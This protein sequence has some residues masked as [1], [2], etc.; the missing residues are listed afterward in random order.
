MH[1][2]LVSIEA[3]LPD[4]KPYENTLEAWNVLGQASKA[5]RY[6]GLVDIA[7]FDDRRNP[8]P[9]I[10]AAEESPAHAF[11]ESDFPSAALQAMPEL[12]RLHVSPPSANQPYLHLEVWCEKSTMNDVLLPL[13]RRY[14]ATLVTGL[15]EQSLTACHLL[16]ERARFSGKPARV[17]Y[18]SD[19]DPA[20][21]SMP[22]A[23]VARKTEFLAQDKNL[24]IRLYPV[25]ADGSTDRGLQPAASADV[26]QGI[27]KSGVRG[28]FEHTHGVG[29]RRSSTHWRRWCPVS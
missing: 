5:A 25:V 14:G 10:F 23:V 22:V 20:G 7:A 4:G 21:Q 18:L 29:A 9:Q 12:P 8:P 6:L 17:I 11:V 15:G 1:Y 2:H 16:V 3:A 27:G 26:R 24:D 13:C 28:G 19:F